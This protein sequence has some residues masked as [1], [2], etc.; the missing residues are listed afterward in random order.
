[1]KKKF[2]T[3]FLSLLF[4]RSN[5]FGDTCTPL[6]IDLT[7]YKDQVIYLDSKN[8]IN[9]QDLKQS[10]FT[11][12]QSFLNGNHDKFISVVHPAIKKTY[13]EKKTI[14]Q[15]ILLDFGLKDSK[16]LLSEILLLQFNGSHLDVNCPNGIARRVVGP[17][18]Q[19]AVFHTALTNKHPFKIMSL[20][21]PALKAEKEFTGFSFEVGLTMVHRYSPIAY[22]LTAKDLQTH[23]QINFDKKHYIPSW[24]EI[25]AARKILKSSQPYWTPLELSQVELQ[26]KDIKN[27]LLKDPAYTFALQQASKEAQIPIEDITVIYQADQLIP[28]L[29]IRVQEDSSFNF[30]REKC[31]KIIKAFLRETSEQTKKY[32]GVECLVY[33]QHEPLSNVPSF[34]SQLIKR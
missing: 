17:K 13:L 10:I 28:G 24:I 27:R 4:I 30:Q 9:L 18:I 16:L 6:P 34:G 33:N 11:F 25:E 2:L 3:Y 5:S 14:F 21:A 12:E 31:E 29:K 20:F 15:N 7:S 22:G 32:S 23:S 26:S 1:M 19:A 8:S